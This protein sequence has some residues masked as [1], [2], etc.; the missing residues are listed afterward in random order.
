M[1][2]GYHMYVYQALYR[3]R[4]IM[5]PHPHEAALLRKCGACFDEPTVRR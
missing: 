1:R 2:E 4:R 5:M 3:P